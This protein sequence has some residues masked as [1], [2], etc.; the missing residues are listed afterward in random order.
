[1]EQRERRRRRAIQMTAV[2]VGSSLVALQAA[3]LILP[4][5]PLPSWSFRALVLLGLAGLPLVLGYVLEGSVRRA[6]DRVRVSV[7]LTRAGLD[8]QMWAATFDRQLHDSFAV[9]EELARLVPDELPLRLEQT[10]R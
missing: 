9:Q 7:R 6:G 1:M 10:P 8:R 5:L 4:V 3:D 2:Y